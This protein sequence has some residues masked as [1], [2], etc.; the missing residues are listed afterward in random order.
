MDNTKTSSK[1]LWTTFRGSFVSV[2]ISLM[3]I[4]MFALII[5]FL[6]ISDNLILPI[7]QG[8]KVVSIFFGVLSAFN[9]RY[10]YK[11]FARGFAIGVIYTILSYTIFSILAGEF[12]F[13]LTSITDMLFGGIIGGISGI[14]VV[15]IKK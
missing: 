6:N 3:L 13:S 4:L 11:G 2:S 12:S 14:I 15:N 9:M 1:I 10:M 5:R 8:I 7:N